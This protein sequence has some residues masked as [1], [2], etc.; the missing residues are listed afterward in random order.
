MNFFRSV[1]FFLA[2]GAVIGMAT[3]AAS[4]ATAAQVNRVQ[5]RETT[6]V[7]PSLEPEFAPLPGFAMLSRRNS[8]P[9]GATRF[10]A[11]GA[12]GRV[13][14][15]RETVVC[16]PSLAVN[17][18]TCYALPVSRFVVDIPL[19]GALSSAPV[20]YDDSWI[21]TTTKGFAVRMRRDVAAASAQPALRSD[22]FSFWGAES[23]KTM[24]QLKRDGQ[25]SADSY[26]WSYSLGTEIVGQPLVF[27]KTFFAFGANQFL[28]ALDVATGRPRWTLR[29]APDT[30]LRLEAAPLAAVP[31]ENQ[32]LVGTSEGILLALSAQNGAIVWRHR[33][34]FSPGQRFPAIVAKPLVYEKSVIVSS[35]EGSTERVSFEK[36]SVASDKCNG[37]NRA[38][39]WRYPLGSIAA[40]RRF[41]NG[42]VIG[43][44]EGTVV[45]L[46]PRN[47]A[48]RWKTPAFSVGAVASM[49]S[50]LLAGT[51][52][53][54]VAF[55][56]GSIAV[57][58]RVGKIL[59]VLP[60]VGESTGEFF[61]GHDPAEVCL[62]FVT[63]GFRCFSLSL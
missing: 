58:D 30:S 13:G 42:V 41:D 52:Y 23:R 59:D 60:P 4:I 43:G 12:L 28:Y 17:T 62:S 22:H 15:V 55:T 20:F 8:V 57:L 6:A 35:A 47:G 45:L 27:E 33:L 54:L 39:E 2:T 49:D 61:A 37:D 1:S 50:V 36:C 29:V 11:S 53:L 40:A 21:A 46:D 32:I 10:R 5:L 48:V 16:G 25:L 19:P 18:L 63:P 14:S 7:F 56:E 34:D 51:E 44:H 38:V 31:S 3:C 9:W 24:A 26:I